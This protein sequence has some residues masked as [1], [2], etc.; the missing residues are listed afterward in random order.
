MQVQNAVLNNMIRG[1]KDPKLRE[2]YGNIISGKYPYK[3]YCMTPGINPRNKKPAHPKKFHIGYVD[4]AGVSLEIQT[5]DKE[6]IPIAGIKSSRDRFDG[7]KGFSCHC[8]NDSIRAAEEQKVI[9]TYKKVPVF[10]R[11]PTRDEIQR[12]F[13]ELQ[14]SGKGP[15][16][17]DK[18]WAIYDGFALEEVG[19]DGV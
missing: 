8:G 7:R 19:P 14:K 3:V 13:G 4:K 1:I 10:A 5:V 16:E 18:G 2:Q 17:F 9:G 15:L 11:P 12:I 6:N